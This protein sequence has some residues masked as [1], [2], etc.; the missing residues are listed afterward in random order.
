[1]NRP[2]DNHELATAYEIRIE[3]HLDRP[4]MARLDG[5][6]LRLDGDGTTVISGPVRDQAAL[7]GVLQRVRDLGLPLVSVT[8]IDAHEPQPVRRRSGLTPKEKNPT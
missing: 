3:G 5:L 4:W 6:F 1:M 2:T 8:R 7:H